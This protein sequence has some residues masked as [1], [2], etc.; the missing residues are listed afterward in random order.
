LERVYNKLIIILKK[1]KI[2]RWCVLTKN[3]FYTFEEE[4]VYVNP[5]EKIEVSKMKD[6]KK[7]T[8]NENQNTFVYIF[9]TFNLYIFFF[10]YRELK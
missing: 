1:L 4:N 3:Y 9:F 8:K 5:T 2:R 7:E 6:V 10:L